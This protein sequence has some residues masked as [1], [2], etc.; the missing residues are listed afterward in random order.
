[1]SNLTAYKNR[2]LELHEQHRH[3]ILQLR[4]AAEVRNCLSD[5][6]MERRNRRLRISTVSNCSSAVSRSP[7][8]PSVAASMP[9]MLIIPHFLTAM[10][11]GV[12]LLESIRRRRPLHIY[13]ES[14]YLTNT[15]RSSE[16]C[17]CMRDED[18]S[19]V[20]G[21]VQ[22]DALADTVWRLCPAMW[23]TEGKSF[24]RRLL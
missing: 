5:T 15:F 11:R 19:T 13:H 12:A 7:M 3:P 18:F 20:S 21:E 2:L 4:D 22:R 16:F 17:T 9:I 10:A 8:L 14:L 24:L 6:L 23:G 1:M